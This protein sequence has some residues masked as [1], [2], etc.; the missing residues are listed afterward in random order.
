MATK[1][2]EWLT[3]EKFAEQAEKEKKKACSNHM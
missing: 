2:W 1:K 3:P